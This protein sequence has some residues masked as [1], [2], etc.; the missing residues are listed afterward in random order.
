MECV[1]NG[2]KFDRTRGDR[3]FCYDHRTE[4]RVWCLARVPEIYSDEEIHQEMFLF[5]SANYEL[6]R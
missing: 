2:C 4:W 6:E 3:F 1:V 5:K